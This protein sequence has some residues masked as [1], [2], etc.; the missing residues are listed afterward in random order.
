MLLEDEKEFQFDPEFQLEVMD[1][2]DELMQ[3]EL[4]EPQEQLIDVE[5]KTKR[6]LIKL[7]E[8]VAEIIENYR[9]GVTTE[10]ELLQVKDFY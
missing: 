10:E 2:N 7:Y 6:V 3:L 8:D 4:D 1:I 5:H 9:E